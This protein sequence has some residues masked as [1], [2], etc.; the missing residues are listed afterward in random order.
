MSSHI[1][2][3]TILA[4]LLATSVASWNN[5]TPW[6]NKRIRSHGDIHVASQELHC[7]FCTGGRQHMLHEQPN[8]KQKYNTLPKLIYS[9]PA[10]L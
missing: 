6:K 1:I 5:H 2:P 10:H 7:P 4:P 9:K 3:S 8:E